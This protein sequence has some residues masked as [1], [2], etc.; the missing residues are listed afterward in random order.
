[1]AQAGD[2]IEDE[3]LEVNSFLPTDITVVEGDTIAW[4]I[5]GF[6]TVSLLSG[7]DRPED[8]IQL[9]DGRLALNP[10]VL[11]PTGSPEYD[12]TGIVNSGLPP[13]EGPAEPFSLTFTAAGT[14]DL[15]CLVH[16]HMDGTVTVLGAGSSAP[17][18]QEELDAMSI[19][20]RDV[21]VAQAEA[22]LVEQEIGLAERP[23]G[24]REYTFLA[25]LHEDK[26]EYLR[27]VPGR[28]FIDVGDTV[29][30]DFAKTEAPH[31][32]TFTSGGEAPEFVLVE[33]QAAGPPNLVV[34]PE[35]ATPAG[36]NVYSGTGFFNSGLLF[37]P[38][39]PPG[40]PTSYAL[41]FN[42]AGS[43]DY[44]CLIHTP[45]MTGTIYVGLVLPNVGGFAVTPLIGSLVGAT[46]L[47]FL[48]GGA[49]LVRRSV[50]TS[51]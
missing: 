14:Y 48:L 15:V 39:G 22:L 24:T 6:H 51:P 16:P 9:P 29:V 1:M 25:G 34:N 47:M 10:V 12:G 30:W 50:R 42:K 37:G 33:P 45:I 7:A 36:G 31:T 21:L 17:S 40:L 46:G 2:F 8:I 5:V 27:F 19:S 28:K 23:D 44:V 26:V 49:Y 32:V 38:E 4:D 20:E 18:T 3:L 41:T 43:Y 35:A 13:E 11:F